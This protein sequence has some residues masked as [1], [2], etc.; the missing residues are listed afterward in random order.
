[1]TT[2]EVFE[3]HRE[4]LFGLA[5]RMLS[6]VSDAQDV[7][8]EAYLRLERQ[9]VASLETPGAWLTTVT[10]RLC[11]DRLRSAQARRE[12][13]VGP[14]LPEPLIDRAG[15]APD[16][17][18]RVTLAES[19]SMA[20][21]V[22]MESLSPAERVAFV[23]HDVFGYGHGEVAQVVGRSEAACRQ[24]VSRARR[25]VR[26]RRPRFEA[27][28][29]ARDRVAEAFLHATLGGDLDALLAVLDPE[30]VLR[31]DGG[32]LVTAARKPIHG[33]DRVARFLQ[34]LRRSL[35]GLEIEP[36]QVNGGHG[37]IARNDGR[38]VAVVALGIAAGRVTDLNI[39][40]NPMK[41]AGLL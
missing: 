28:P 26:E 16:P 25:H 5:Y 10:S 8:Q 35:A 15:G 20:F 40:A 41:L 11:L 36:A 39:V 21:L 27:D 22:V 31:S 33:A 29:G 13:Y 1:M 37:F 32:G 19:I 23:L 17:A 7:V 18:D 2:V 34:G 3:E 24:L 38:L 4:R 6:S 9:G 30:V 12:T 14:W